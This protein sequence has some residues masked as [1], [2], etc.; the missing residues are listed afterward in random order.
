MYHRYV[1]D[2]PS[3]QA[4]LGSR[5]CVSNLGDDSLQTREA[6][7]RHEVAADLQNGHVTHACMSV[8]GAG[9]ATHQGRH[10]K[11]LHGR[12]EMGT[13]DSPG[14]GKSVATQ[15]RKVGKELRGMN[16]CRFVKNQAA[17]THF[18]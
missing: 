16:S 4:H 11:L 2:K 3:K 12:S 14:R 8:W 10:D 15:R 6:H 13:D 1:R 7:T 9:A 5:H 17:S 18:L